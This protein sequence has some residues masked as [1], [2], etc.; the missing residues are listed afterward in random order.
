MLL[1]MPGLLILRYIAVP[2]LN[3]LAS[4]AEPMQQTAE[5]LQAI[6]ETLVP[7]GA[8]FMDLMLASLMAGPALASLGL[9]LVALSIATIIAT[10]GLFLLKLLGLPVFEAIGNAA[11]SLD[12]AAKGLASMAGGLSMMAMSLMILTPFLPTLAAVSAFTA[13]GGGIM[14]GKEGEEGGEGEAAQPKEV[15][16][17][18][19]TMKKMAEL[20]ANAVAKVKVEPKVST[21]IWADGNRNAS[22]DYQG[23]IQN[24]TKLA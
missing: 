24:Q 14:G 11:P 2:A 19:A 1:A 10:P 13:I 7:L 16:L 4:V 18:D 3:A 23:Q 22:G 8:A 5:A 21:D 12:I 20:V 6:T 15:S 17:D 9:G